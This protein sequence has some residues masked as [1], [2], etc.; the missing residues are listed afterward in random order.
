MTAFEEKNG[1]KAP[2]NGIKWKR[3]G[4]SVRL[5]GVPCSLGVICTPCVICC[6]WPLCFV[7]KAICVGRGVATV[8]EGKGGAAKRRGYAGEHGVKGGDAS[9]EQR[10]ASRRISK[11]KAP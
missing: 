9:A 4:G 11:R 1:K 7:G 3:R 5:R 10:K 6:R 8:M 2:K